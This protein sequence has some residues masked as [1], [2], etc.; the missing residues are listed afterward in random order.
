MSTDLPDAV[1][2][3]PDY[4]LGREVGRG[5]FG[6]VWSARH[7]QLGRDVA[8]KQLAGPVTQNREH[9]SRF[10]REARILAQMDHPH[11]VTVYDYR[12]NDQVRLLVMELLTGGTFAD[13]RAA[14]MSLETAIASTLAAASGLHHVHEQGILHRDVKPENLMFDRRGTLKVTDFGIARGDLMDATAINL[15]HAGEFFGTPAYVSPEQAGQTLGEGWAP[16]DAASDQYS[17]A[18][19]LY[20]ALSDRLTHDIAGGAVALCTRRMNDDPRPLRD[21]A[22]DVPAE[23]E[24]V[25]MKALARDPR[26][27]FSSTEDFAVA[28]GVAVTN[29]LGPDW[30]ARSNVPIRET[31]AILDAPH[32]R[33]QPS[34]PAAAQ[35]V[36]PSGM[37]TLLFTDVEGSTKLWEAHPDAMRVALA[38]HDTLVRTA[39]ESRGGYVFKTV[40]DAFCAAFPDP[41]TAVAAAVAIQRD[42]TGEEWPATTPVRVRIAIHTGTCDERDGD[43]FGRPVNRVARLEAIAHGGQTLVSGTT[44]GLLTDHR[45]GDVAL[46]DLGRHRLKDL[47][48]PEHVWQLT[49][50]GLPNDFPALRSLSNPRLQTN[51]P[52]QTT[53]F[54]G[55][56]RELTELTDLLSTARLVTI[57]GP[58]GVGKTRLALQTSVELLDGSGD[59]VWLV[60]LAPVADPGQVVATVTRALGIRDDPTRDPLEYLVDVCLDRDTLIV[61]DNCEHVLDAVAKLANELLQRCPLV[62]L[63]A[64]SREPLNIRGEHVYRIPALALPDSAGP[65]NAIVAAA[66]VQLFVEPRSNGGSTWCSSS[67]SA[68][69]NTT[70]SSPSTTRT[71]RSSRASAGVSTG[72]RWRSSLPPPGSVRSRSSNSMRAS[73]NA[74]GS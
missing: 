6:I 17:L 66:A 70:T 50:D 8:I 72:F 67:S 1:R 5:Q 39:V 13:R 64:T 15:T 23:I 31:G 59:G 44:A 11:V 68:S 69:R 45:P 2:A 71:L 47:D 26:F 53:N 42:V 51:L 74:S 22:P 24:A 34:E 57:V 43:Y 29:A 3:L 27:R 35:R 60:E 38:R 56:D 48:Q 21:V 28:L 16:I 46:V 30:L 73:T 36:P 19:V 37:V 20:E 63:I 52:V 4:E 25:V 49:V 55:R 40:G 58:G 33:R 7:R 10:R 12:E 14:R 61:L 18:A 9:S 32:P 65:T 54:L 41:A 62:A